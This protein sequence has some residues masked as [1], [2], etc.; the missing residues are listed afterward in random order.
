MVG[1]VRSLL[2][3]NPAGRSDWKECTVVTG[4]RRGSDHVDLSVPEA[5]DRLAI[6][7]LVDAY[8]Y[9]ADRRDVTGQMVKM[10]FDPS[11]GLLKNVLYDT[12][13]ATGQVSVSE[14]YSDYRDAAGMKLPFSVVIT[15]GGQK[16]QEVT[17]KSIKVNT[18]I[19]LQ[20]LEKRQ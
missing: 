18:G 1:P 11:T 5:A 8:A 9:Y 20:E 14:T 2:I 3:A 7:E 16:L 13:T 12:I 17:V 15:V 10:V 4:M 19:K 6:R